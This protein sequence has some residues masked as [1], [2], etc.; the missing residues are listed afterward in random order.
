MKKRIPFALVK[1]INVILLTMPFLA[2]WLYYYGPKTSTVGSRQVTVLV[3]L[4]FLAL[5]Y[6]FCQRLDCFRVSV[7]QIRDIVFGQVLA[8]M[9]S[10]VMLYVLIWM[11]ISLVK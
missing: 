6:F 1:L 9:I 11:H 5:C 2:C 4:I 3:L 10:D 8:T 7:L